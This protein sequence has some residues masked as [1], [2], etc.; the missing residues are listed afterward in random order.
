ME[1]RDT[2][3]TKIEEINMSVNE[4]AAA[5]GLMASKQKA[6][7]EAGKK[8]SLGHQSG[9]G[10]V[11]VE[12]VQSDDSGITQALVNMRDFGEMLKWTFGVKAEEILNHMYE[13]SETNRK[14][15]LKE[16][17]SRGLV[18]QFEGKMVLD[19]ES[20]NA[21]QGEWFVEKPKDKSQGG[22]HK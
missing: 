13:I 12:N 9:N 19:T 21:W 6:L 18:L 11:K 14:I 22:Q 17:V 1:Q 10:F 5:E 3:T 20:H 16:D 15:N 7:A 8:I 4:K 2:Y